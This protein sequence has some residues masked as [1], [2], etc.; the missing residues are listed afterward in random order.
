MNNEYTFGVCICNNIDSV[1]PNV[2][3]LYNTIDYT[4]ACRYYFDIVKL[5]NFNSLIKY[6]DYYVI[7][8]R[9]DGTIEQWEKLIQK[10]KVK[11]VKL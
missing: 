11:L 5:I 4:D 2:E 10:T 6:N 8:I 9:K 1:N 3:M 7:F